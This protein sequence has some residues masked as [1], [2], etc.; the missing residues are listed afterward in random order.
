MTITIDGSSNDEAGNYIRGKLRAWDKCL[1]DG[2]FLEMTCWSYVANLIVKER[3]RYLLESIACIR[4]VIKYVKSSSA[5]LEIFK[6]S[7][8]N[9]NAE[10]RSRLLLD[11]PTWWNSTYLMLEAATQ[12]R[13]A[14]EQLREDDVNN[15]FVS[16]F[17]DDEA[18]KKKIGHPSVEDWN[19]VGA[20]VEILKILYDAT[21]KF[22]ASL[23]V[24]ST[25]YFLELCGIQ[26]ELTKLCQRRDSTLGRM[27]CSMKRKY[28]K[29]WGLVDSNQMLFVLVV[30]DPRCKMEFVKYLFNELLDADSAAQMTKKVE[31]TLMSLYKYYSTRD[32]GHT[33]QVPKKTSTSVDGQALL[34]ISTYKKW[35]KERNC[36][37]STTE[38]DRYFLA[39][40]EN[41][42]D[43]K[44]D[45]LH[46]WKVNSSKYPILSLIARDVLDILVSS[47]AS[48]SAFN[49]GDRVLDVFHSS[50]SPKILEAS[51]CA[52]NWLRSIP[53]LTDIRIYMDDLK[54]YEEIE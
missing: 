36:S 25:A 40:N 23:P 3:L 49:I 9:E 1:L 31:S 33:T 47:T 21:L 7:M 27:A 26:S 44:F 38:V 30:L 37:A 28:E 34:L 24:T 19:N 50:L 18:A 2:E 13:K 51:I 29:Y 41:L 4:N 54:K 17:T 10:C 48:E 11:V 43:D 15:H 45:V 8:Q 35:L 22:N 53:I 46:W 52:Q 6:A 5:R 39:S 12:F 20:F 14:F 42:E 16:N 32:F